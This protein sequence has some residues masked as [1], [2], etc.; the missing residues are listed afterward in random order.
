MNLRSKLLA[1]LLGVS[2][3]PLTI[4][5]FLFF[6]SY[7]QDLTQSVDRQLRSVAAIQQS[8]L[9]AI[10]LQNQERLALVA[11]RT[12][13]RI[14]LERFLRT[15]DPSDQL[16]M[17]KILD[18]A[19]GSI[20]D[21]EEITVYSPEGVAV[22]TTDSARVG[23]P[24]FDLSLFRQSLAGPQVDRIIR[25]DT[26]RTRILFTGPMTLD[27]VTIGSILIRSRVQNLQ[28]SLL[29]YSGLGRTGETILV[30]P[31]QGEHLVFLAPSRFD[32]NATFRELTWNRAPG[33]PSEFPGQIEGH[34]RAL[35]YRNTEVLAVSCPVPETD[36]ILVVKIDGEEAFAGL[37]QAAVQA[38]TF[39]SALTLLILLVA[40]R[41]SHH[42]SSPLVELAGA[43]EA[44]AEGNYKG[45]VQV[46]SR[47][48]IGT[49]VQG[50]NQMARE[51]AS[52][53][54]ALEEKVEELEGAMTEI[55]TLKEIIPICASCKKIRDD[56]GYWN[57]L[58]SYLR[59]HSDLEFSHGLCPDCYREF[60]KEL[61]QS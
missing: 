49:L 60:E 58:E 21:L 27:G 37:E 18:D 35:D 36:W 38:L 50:F 55:K 7:R 15:G 23:R 53:Q 2:L 39:F 54:T 5:G 22:A 14:S 10:M 17:T 29:D 3:L 4:F 61:D 1:S 9:S 48:E 52:S 42:L 6:Q 41:L 16:R 13:L 46:T 26:G 51:V 11:S 44:I 33:K 28:A 12:Q 34:F 20:A 47:D 19:V 30:H 56:R 24:H 8:R 25:T 59:I 43:A 32:S 45:E 57:Q 40:H 31:R